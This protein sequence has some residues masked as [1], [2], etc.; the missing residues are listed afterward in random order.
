MV[1]GLVQRIMRGDVPSNLLDMRLIALDMG[2]LMAGDEVEVGGAKDEVQAGRT[3]GKIVAK[4]PSYLVSDSL[5]S[6]LLQ[7]QTFYRSLVEKSY[8]KQGCSGKKQRIFIR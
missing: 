1:E 7:K 8:P 4:Q 2:A 3:A 5:Y 6:G